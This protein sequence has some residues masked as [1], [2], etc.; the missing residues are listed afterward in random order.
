MPR[1]NHQD[2]RGNVP[3]DIETY[4][5]IAN[6]D[7][8]FLNMYYLPFPTSFLT[9]EDKNLE[10]TIQNLAEAD[11]KKEFKKIMNEHQP[12]ILSKTQIEDFL[13]RANEDQFTDFLLVPL[14]RKMGFEKVIAKGHK[15]RIL[16]FGQDIKLMKLRLLTDHYLYFVSQIKIGTIG[17]SSSQP[18]QEIEGILSEIRP[19]FNK[20]IFDP[21]IGRNITPDHVYLITS[22]RIGEQAK[23]YLYEQIDKSQR[24]NLL[25]LENHQ[26]IELYFKYGLPE[27]DQKE[28][29]RIITEV[30]G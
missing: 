28:I 19:A 27:K 23:V 5:H 12:P 20:S 14:F 22:G 30:E 13:D 24:R 3:R 9:E 6:R 8:G 7:L 4:C 17:A 18:T 16:E 11:Y 10:E 26:L 29:I 2:F 25:L 15:E 1:F 21:D